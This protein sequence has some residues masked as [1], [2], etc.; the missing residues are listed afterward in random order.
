MNMSIAK[1]IIIKNLKT[2]PVVDLFCGIGGMTHGFVKKGFRVIAGID[3]DLSCKYAYEKNNQAKFIHKDVDDIEV[4]EVISL[5]PKNSIKILIGCAPCQPFSTYTQKRPKNRKKWS[6]LY[7]FARL[8][9]ET[10]PEIISMENVPWLIKFKPPPVFDDFVGSLKDEGYEVF[11]RLVN[12]A[13]YGVPQ[14][15]IRLVLIASKFGKINLINVTHSPNNYRT[16]RETIGY[17]DPIEDGQICPS[18]TLHR[19]SKL[20]ELNKK[21]I[22]SSLPGGTWRDWDESLVA[23][24]HKKKSGRNYGSVYGRMEWNKPAPT[25]TTQCYG[26]GNGRFGHPEQHR[27]ISLREAALLQTFPPDYDFMAPDSKVSV[28]IIGRHIGN[29]VPVKLGEIIAQSIKEH[30]EAYNV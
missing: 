23:E 10:Q 17:L 18:D 4:S 20:S 9:K 6:L 19:T 16:V 11:H 14:N 25:I 24:C 28:R 21:R 8:I 12:C 27:A 7:S 22:I 30:L 29:A 3:T 2:F 13:D 26:F 15:R 1:N 5:Y